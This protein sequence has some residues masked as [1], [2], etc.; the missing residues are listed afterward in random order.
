MQGDS[1]HMKQY[2]KY[3]S[4]NHKIMSTEVP[5]SVWQSRWQV[6][7]ESGTF[8]KAD[9]VYTIELQVSTPICGGVGTKIQ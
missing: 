7:N 3:G 9:A 6:A 2:S 8:H 4:D 5:K 1:S